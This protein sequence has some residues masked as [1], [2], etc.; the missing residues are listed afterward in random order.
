MSCAVKDLGSSFPS[1]W[2]VTLLLGQV[3][4]NTAAVPGIYGA[5]P[6]Q[7]V[8]ALQSSTKQFFLE[9]DSRRLNYLGTQIPAGCFIA[10][11]TQMAQPRVL[12]PGQQVLGWCAPFGERF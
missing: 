8:P 7:P 6:S 3:L 9:G 1:S 12:R 2:T 10:W 5:F 11:Q 4:T